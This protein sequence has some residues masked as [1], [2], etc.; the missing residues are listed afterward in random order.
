MSFMD[1]N[2]LLRTETARTL[3]HESAK[4][5]PIIDYHC[6]LSAK[7]IYENIPA[8]NL[9]QLWLNDDHYKW[10]AMR[11]NGED[12]RNI[13]GDGSDYDKFLAFARTLP[14][15]VGNPLYHWSHLELKRYFGITESLCE[16][17]A[18]RI[19]DKVNAC[20]VDGRHTPQS[21]IRDSNVY[22]LCTT[23]DP[24]DDLIYHE[25][26]RLS[27]FP[28]K[29]L[30]AWRPEAVMDIHLPAWRGN[31][32]RL[33][34]CA[35][36]SIR[37]YSDLK[38]ALLAR[39]EV[40][41]AHGCVASDHAFERMPY[42][43]MAEE[44]AEACF[45]KALANERLTSEE[46]DGYKTNLMLWLS[47]EYRRRNWAMEIHIGKLGSVNAKMVRRIGPARGFDS[48]ADHPLAATL[49]AFMNDL[50]ERDELPKTILFSLNDNDYSALATMA[51]NFP[52]EGVPGKIQFGTAWWFQDHKQGME[53]QMRTLAAQNLLGRFIGM[54]TDSRSFLSYAR[55]EYFRRI[56]CGMLGSMVEDGEY[57]DDLPWLRKMVG[58]I[59]FGNAKR[60]FGL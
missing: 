54:L 22:A 45:A 8:Q 56:L 40:F 3:F 23:D 25:K 52:E 32:R 38:R 41:A 6:H 47:A 50:E 51:G 20:L 10:R 48:V 53:K 24:A 26:L 37:S 11:I 44:E 49:G 17:S 5:Q 4:M 34:E 58:D 28:V 59:S 1:E 9:T 42:Q 7:E 18:P 29:V 33:E 19:W 13:T 35:A 36:L 57:P 60:Y 12:E 46:C 31:V 43:P 14:H 27:G 39:M 30:P 15:A 2:F 55:H 21:F 16:E